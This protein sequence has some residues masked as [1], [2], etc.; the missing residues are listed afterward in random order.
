M[1]QVREMIRLIEEAEQKEDDG[2]WFDSICD[3]VSDI[4]SEVVGAVA[5]LL[6]ETVGQPLAEVVD[7][8]DSLTGLKYVFQQMNIDLAQLLRDPET[9]EALKGFTKGVVDFALDASA[10]LATGGLEILQ[11]VMNGESVSEACVNRLSDLGNSFAENILDNPQFWTVFGTA[12]KV[13]AI[14]SAAMTGGAAGLV[15]VGVMALVELDQ[16]TNMFEKAFGEGAAPWVRLGVAAVGLVAGGAMSQPS[17]W[18]PQATQYMQA[19]TAIL[20]GAGTIYQGIKQ[21]DALELE[22]DLV[23][24]RASIQETASKMAMLRR[25][26]DECLNELKDKNED[27]Q[28]KQEMGARL[29]QTQGMMKSAAIMRA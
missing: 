21:H 17:G 4:V 15:A 11:A 9:A 26:V 24:A 5:N 23:E 8:V 7:V 10:F 20:Q 29:V 3:V 16:R 22:A 18:L 6:V 19:G 1:A 2:G 13:A 27:R 14:A 12:V 25:L 28:S